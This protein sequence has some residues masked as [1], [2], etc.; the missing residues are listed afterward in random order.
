MADME[1]IKQKI[2]DLQT[3]LDELS[4]EISGTEE[5]MAEP[6][7]TEEMVEPEQQEGDNAGMSA[8]QQF[9]SKGVRRRM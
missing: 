9:H 1:M 6:P 4:A 3:G 2:A 7:G 5:P 8:L